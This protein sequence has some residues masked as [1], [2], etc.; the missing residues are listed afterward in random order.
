MDGTLFVLNTANGKP[1]ASLPT[2]GWV[3]DVSIDQ[4]RQRIYATNGIGSIDIYAIEPNDVYHRL[5][6]VKSDVLA[7]TSLYSSELDRLFVSMP[8]L[9]ET[10]GGIMVFKPSP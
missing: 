6:S 1:V 8:Y 3:D 5:A 9:G 7:K 2:G 10:P 4:K